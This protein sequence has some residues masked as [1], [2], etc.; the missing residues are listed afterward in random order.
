MMSE[1]VSLQKYLFEVPGGLREMENWCKAVASAMYRE[2]GH[3]LTGAMYCRYTAPCP[4]MYC[5]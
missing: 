2:V 1:G 4:A 5:T 3:Y